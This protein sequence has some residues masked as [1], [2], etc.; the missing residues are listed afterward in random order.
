MTHVALYALCGLIFAVITLPKWRRLIVFGF[1][2]I[3][4][5]T[6]VRKEP[7]LFK[8]SLTLPFT[9]ALPAWA[10]LLWYL[11]SKLFDLDPVRLEGFRYVL[12]CMLAAL[13]A[14]YLADQLMPNRY[15]GLLA[16]PMLL[17]SFFAGIGWWLRPRFCC[18][19]AHGLLALA[20]GGSIIAKALGGAA[21]ALPWLAAG[22]LTSYH[23]IHGLIVSGTLGL[24]Q[25]M[26]LSQ[27]PGILRTASIAA[28]ML[29]LSPLILLNISQR[30]RRD[31][32]PPSQEIDYDLW[33]RLLASRTRNVFAL[34]GLDERTGGGGLR[35]LTS[36][37]A[38]LIA[39]GLIAIYGVIALNG[40]GPI[41][42]ITPTSSLDHTSRVILG[43]QLV[44]LVG[45]S[46]FLAQ[47]V[48]VDLLRLRSCVPLALS[49]GTTYFTFFLV[50]YWA[51][52]ANN[53]LQGG[54]FLGATAALLCVA[55]LTRPPL[56]DHSWL[57]F[58]SFV[59]LLAWTPDPLSVSFAANASLVGL[60]LLVLVPAV[61]LRLRDKGVYVPVSYPQALRRKCLGLFRLDSQDHVS[62]FLLALAGGLALLAQR[63]PGAIGSGIDLRLPIW[64]FVLLISIRLLLRHQERV[65]PIAQSWEDVQK[66]AKEH[67][68]P[69]AF[70]A[71]PPDIPGFETFSHRPKMLDILEIQ[72]CV[73][74]PFL[75]DQVATRCA[76]FGVDVGDT[77]KNELI[78]RLGASYR[79][80]T[81]DDL[82]CLHRKFGV[83]YVVLERRALQ[84]NSWKSANVVHQNEHFVVV[85]PAST[86]ALRPTAI[87]N[88]E[89]RV[90]TP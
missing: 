22:L 67:T 11:P 4:V 1:S 8:R 33:W 53:A 48:F 6:L 9:R 23:P 17:G 63:I 90:A 26:G 80:M 34:A 89:I 68:A 85:T 87:G 42:F 19:A 25:V 74:A 36:P 5:Q 86:G 18:Y 44:W 40:G 37:P 51:F 84:S 21:G 52:L 45:L 15:L 3:V 73:Y 47:L 62:I 75:T 49:R 70:F 60:G 14:G 27:Q 35:T 61:G 50:S 71:T 41:A 69:G 43:G 38:L 39:V 78:S 2:D 64:I 24:F 55:S 56:R 32:G 31:K 29:G 76:A 72:Y 66:W 7:E 83:Q 59:P 20:I 30:Y 13:P 79:A 82:Y 54:G 65:E 12:I 28:W 58:L 16:I 88:E 57:V 46:G 81:E 77:P 10:D